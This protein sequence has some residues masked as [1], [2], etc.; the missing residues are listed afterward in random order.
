MSSA[1]PIVSIVGRSGTGKTTLVERLLGE[2]KARG[3]RVA[4]IKHDTHTFEIDQPGKDS[5]RHAQAGSDVVVIASPDRLAIIRRLEREWSLDEI[6]ALIEDVDIIITE[7]YKRG[8][9]PKIEVS[10]RERGRGLVS[11]IDELVAVATDEPYPEL[12]V[13]QLALDDAAGLV[14]LIEKL[15]LR[16]AGGDAS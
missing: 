3:Y 14:D 1:I 7:G 15:F 10:R 16:R 6:A 9:K 5:W 8:G 4:T 12:A 13:P 11:Q 2:L